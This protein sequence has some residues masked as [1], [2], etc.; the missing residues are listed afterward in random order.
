MPAKQKVRELRFPNLGVVRRAGPESQIAFTEP[1]PTPWAVNCRPE[2]NLDLRLRGGSRP[3]LTKHYASSVG[4]AI[5]GLA[6]IQTATS[7]TNAPALAIVVD[8]TLKVLSGGA[9]SLPTSAL[10]TTTG[11]AVL[12][13]TGEAILV[14]GGSLPASCFLCSSGQTV[15]AISST[16]VTSAN[17]VTGILDTLTATSGT[18]PTG[19]THSAAYRK[20]LLLAGADNGVYVSRQ[21]DFA[22][23]DY[24]ADTGDSSRATVLQL[25]EADEIGPV[26]TAI[27][28]FKDS[29][30][31]MASRW[32]LWLLTGD[33]VTGSQRNVSRGVGI[34]SSTA[35]CTVMD[36]RVGDMPVKYGVLFLSPNGLYMATPTGDSLESLSEDR[37]PEELRDIAS[38][39]T[40][41]MVYSPKDRGVWIYLKPASGTTTHWFFDLAR[42]G[43][44]PVV[45]QTDHYPLATCW[46]EGD[47]V[48]GCSDGYLREVS[49]SSDDST[50][51]TSHLLLGPLRLGGP[52]TF[53]MLTSIHGMVAQDSGSVT[54]RIVT[55]R[56]ADEACDNA[57][58]AIEAYVAGDTSTATAYAE[59][60]GT[61]TAGRSTTRYPRVRSM[62]MVVWLTSTAEWAYEGITATSL[63]TGHW[64]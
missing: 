33:P 7:T 48:L 25:A 1:Y 11:E 58:A 20:R 34:I 17:V 32:T 60:T 6:S 22:D 14:G 27:I 13:T 51:I 15:Y 30:C 59:A 43:F 37:L 47:V 2:D 56:T 24:G 64:R 9:L 18:V 5:T 45:L 53:G 3:G 38:T 36:A 10:L 4:S 50:A 52:N 21:G 55:G 29:S 28:P 8:S 54:W 39:T 41:S 63:D 31:L 35:W 16:S 26:C 44:W 12:T 40:V 57:K 61:W 46:H 49:G 62:W 19:C 42:K 23:W